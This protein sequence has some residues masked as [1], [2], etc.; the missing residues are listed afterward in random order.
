MSSS[1]GPQRDAKTSI[2]APKAGE[3]RD[4][5]PKNTDAKTPTPT[6]GGEISWGSFGMDAAVLVLSSTFRKEAGLAIETVKKF[7]A[8]LQSYFEKFST[9]KVSLEEE[10]DSMMESADE[11]SGATLK[12]AWGKFIE[13][14]NQLQESISKIEQETEKSQPN[15]NTLVKLLGEVITKKLPKF[16][17]AFKELGLNEKLEQYLPKNYEE[18]EAKFSGVI[19]KITPPDVK[20]HLES[21]WSLLDKLPTKEEFAKYERLAKASIL[22][23]LDPINDLSRTLYLQTDKTGIELGIKEGYIAKRKFDT[24]KGKSLHD[25]YKLLA[26]KYKEYYEAAGYEFKAEIY[27]FA[28]SIDEQRQNLLKECEEKLALEEKKEPKD[29]LKIDSLHGQRDRIQA[30][31]ARSL[32]KLN[33]KIKEEQQ[34]PDAKA[35]TDSLIERRESV[36]K[37]IQAML[38]EV[39]KKLEGACGIELARLIAQRK[40]LIAPIEKIYDADEKGQAR[41]EIMI[42]LYNQPPKEELEQDEK[43]FL[44]NEESILDEMKALGSSSTE[45]AIEKIQK[46]VK[47]QRELPLLYDY[48]VDL[49]QDIME[50]K[51]K[52][53]LVRLLQVRAEKIAEIKK[54]NQKISEEKDSKKCVKLIIARNKKLVEMATNYDVIV[55]RLTS[56]LAR[57]NKKID[58]EKNPQLMASLKKQQDEVINTIGNM[59]R[60]LQVKLAEAPDIQLP[61]LMARRKRLIGLIEN[62]V[63]PDQPIPEKLARLICDNNPLPQRFRR[64]QG[65]SERNET[66]LNDAKIN[67]RNIR[68]IVKEQQELPLPL[69]CSESVYQAI[70]SAKDKAAL[71]PF[72]K[73]RKEEM[74]QLQKENKAIDDEKENSKRAALIVARNRKLQKMANETVVN[75]DAPKKKKT[76][77]STVAAPVVKDKKSDS[78]GPMYVIKQ[79]SR[80]LPEAK[81]N[82]RKIANNALASIGELRKDSKD[83]KDTSSKIQQYKQAIKDILDEEVYDQCFTGVVDAKRAVADQ[84][85]KKQEK[86]LRKHKVISK[87]KE[88]GRKQLIINKMK[89]VGEINQLL[90]DMVS[91]VEAEHQ[92]DA[93]HGKQ[94]AK[95]AVAAMTAATASNKA[96]HDKKDEKD[97]KQDTKQ[98]D[99]NKVADVKKAAIIQKPKA[100]IQRIG[101]FVVGAEQTTALL[102]Y[103][104]SGEEKPRATPEEDLVYSGELA[105]IATASVRNMS[106]AFL[107]LQEDEFIQRLTSYVGM[108][109][110]IKDKSQSVV[111][112]AKE[113]A[114]LLPDRK[115]ISRDDTF[116]KNAL[117]IVRELHG[118]LRDLYPHDSKAKDKVTPVVDNLK[119]LTEALAS[120][121]EPVG[122]L[123]W[124]SFSIGQRALLK[125]L[126]DNLP[127]MLSGLQF[128]GIETFASVLREINFLFRDLV[129]L[130]DNI[131]VTFYLK[132]GYLKN[133]PID[134]NKSLMTFIKEF[135]D[136]VNETLGFEFTPAERFPYDVAIKQQREAMLDNTEDEFAK[137]FIKRRTGVARFRVDGRDAAISSLLPPLDVRGKLPSLSSPEAINTLLKDRRIKLETE[138]KDHRV[139]KVKIE[140]LKKLE[141]S[142]KP[143]LDEKLTELAQDAKSLPNMYLLYEGRTQSTLEVTRKRF[144]VKKSDVVKMID[145][146]IVDL[147]KQRQSSFWRKQPRRNLEIT[148][149]AFEVLR[150]SIKQPGYQFYD[151]ILELKAKTFAGYELLLAEENAFLSKVQDLDKNII[152][153]DRGKKLIG[154]QHILPQTKKKKMIV[155]KPEVSR[156]DVQDGR[157]HKHSK[158]ETSVSSTTADHKYGSGTASVSAAAAENKSVSI[159]A[160]TVSATGDTKGELSVSRSSEQSVSASELLIRR[161][162]NNEKR[163]FYNDKFNEIVLKIQG[164]EN[165]LARAFMVTSTKVKKNNLLK[166]ISQNFKR[167]LTWVKAIDKVR[168]LHPDDFYLLYEGRTGAMMRSIETGNLSKEGILHRIE[169]EITRLQAKRTDSL[170]FFAASRKAALESHIL[171]LNALRNGIES[172]DTLQM[173]LEKNALYKKL[174]ET[175]DKDLL[176]EIRVWELPAQGQKKPHMVLTDLDLQAAKQQPRS[177]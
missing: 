152:A 127:I 42:D 50:E 172:G 26:T 148:I 129:L 176:E 177:K 107:K 86:M 142:K 130:L 3:S 97:V 118:K 169:V 1:S 37:T 162:A 85:V 156:S 141:E 8:G 168:E 135:H 145:L 110:F 128:V 92:K 25:F 30:R 117:N 7:V 167:G 131:E 73:K 54:D 17:E 144:G 90:Q 29:Q 155:S 108:T 173:F 138:D 5:S 74:Q 105:E 44:L 27:P 77:A 67:E 158:V 151:A 10:L 120:P 160:T 39:Q 157:D 89:E 99:T 28:K 22:V 46:L 133:Y 165:E 15:T 124:I 126:F 146:K 55:Q 62:M 132:E 23:L 71:T 69:R 153:A 136:T 48:P 63:Q 24:F 101:E 72:L 57:V 139:K 64:F 122:K 114:Q 4:G 103:A 91:K 6:K 116:S 87:I 164:R 115:E 52:D 96:V 40:R 161:K 147:K 41:L 175:E 111:D 174:L 2:P 98:A 60:D 150:D 59:L 149:H 93:K 12:T 11:I 21:S 68:R 14:F 88:I 20:K 76:A 53:K 78:V 56:S 95:Q 119:L 19:D 83:A 106:E 66:E 81:T 79:L 94:D 154:E 134:E 171:A 65:T 51:D 137:A 43:Q 36:I 18:L 13:A 84:R 38:K 32:I 9:I 109:D 143:T 140:L 100:W 121:L 159:A 166:A 33:A 82:L 16:L 31:I 35:L 47:T 49:Y 61:R 45:Q 163:D 102:K 112:R 80:L 123:Q 58:N 70:L 170:W 104:L 75:R 34:K 113:S 125:Q